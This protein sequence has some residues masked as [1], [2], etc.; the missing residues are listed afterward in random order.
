MRMG[1]SVSCFIFH[2]P[3]VRLSLRSVLLDTA[4]FFVQGFRACTTSGNVSSFIPIV[5]ICFHHLTT[6]TK[7]SQQHF[8]QVSVGDVYR[9][10]Y[11]PH[12]SQ[13]APHP[14][15]D[16]CKFLV[17][18]NAKS[19]CVCWILLRMQALARLH[20]HVFS[21]AGFSPMIFFCSPFTTI[22]VWFFWR[23]YG[24]RADD[25]FDSQYP[26]PARLRI[27]VV[28]FNWCRSAINRP[29]TQPTIV[30]SPFCFLR[31]FFSVFEVLDLFTKKNSLSGFLPLKCRDFDGQRRFGFYF[32]CVN[33][34]VY[35][36]S[37]FFCLN[38]YVYSW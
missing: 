18:S 5:I 30:F 12:S 2:S 3:L 14:D 33:A 26:R 16:S 4:N 24:I 1:G 8:T 9:I 36:R 11:P 23:F 25:A 13:K 29:M 34:V 20:V 37:W 38:R 35:V 6:T 28:I 10:F 19:K 31:V 27:Y 15:P 21:P 22:T 7:R 32:T 17:C